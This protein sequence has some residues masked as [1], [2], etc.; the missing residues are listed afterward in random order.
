MEFLLNNLG[1]NKVVLDIKTNKY[2]EVF[3][4]TKENYD[5]FND[6]EDIIDIYKEKTK[7]QSPSHNQTKNIVLDEFICNILL[8]LDPTL[9]LIP[10]KSI[11]I[12]KFRADLKDK[13]PNYQEKLKKYNIDIKDVMK[14]ISNDKED[15]SGFYRY[16]AILLEKSI[17]IDTNGE[18]CLYQMCSNDACVLIGKEPIEITVKECKERICQFNKEKHIKNN[19]IDKIDQLI[20]KDLKEIAEEIG[21]AIYKLEGGKKKP[22]L[23]AELK[24]NVKNMLT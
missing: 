5:S 24:E 23:K 21:A 8:H 12:D 2:E 15:R 10:D 7:T 18:I 13:L 22:L 14:Q 17:A 9:S 19:T 20:V 11:F 6:I 4:Y 3:D 1:T 16:I